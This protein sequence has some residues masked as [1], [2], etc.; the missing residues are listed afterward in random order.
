M[1]TE[2]QQA[3]LAREQQLLD[4]VKNNGVK[5]LN[6][7]QLEKFRN[8]FFLAANN[9]RRAQLLLALLSGLAPLAVTVVRTNDT[10]IVAAS[11]VLGIAL[12]LPFLAFYVL[13]VNS[14]NVP[15]FNKLIIGAAMYATAVAGFMIMTALVLEMLAIVIIPILLA[16]FYLLELGKLKQLITT[17]WP[18]QTQP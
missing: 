18:T 16:Y 5:S 2:K 6:R 17:Q 11:F 3:Q 8:H 9:L 14:D 13:L 12:A 4:E 7:D 10:T 1:P 15:R